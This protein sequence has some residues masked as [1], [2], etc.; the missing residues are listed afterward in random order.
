MQSLITHKLHVNARQD[1]EKVHYECS[2]RKGY[3]IIYVA[4]VPGSGNTV[5]IVR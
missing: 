4:R 5:F 1:F 2:T 3:Y